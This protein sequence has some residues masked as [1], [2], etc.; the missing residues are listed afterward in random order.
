MFLHHIT[1]DDLHKSDMAG[2]GEEVEC[3]RLNTRLVDGCPLQMILG[4]LRVSRLAVSLA[5]GLN[6][7]WAILGLLGPGHIRQSGLW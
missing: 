7:S 4:K 1:V 2:L 3:L 5:H 6:G